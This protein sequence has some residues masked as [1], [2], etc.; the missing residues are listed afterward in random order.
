MC[1]GWYLVRLIYLMYLLCFTPALLGPK[2][3]FKDPDLQLE[4]DLVY[5][6]DRVDRSWASLLIVG[7]H[8]YFVD[9]HNGLPCNRC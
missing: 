7:A 8:E 2:A 6:T 1:D 5:F 4:L 3:R 9:N